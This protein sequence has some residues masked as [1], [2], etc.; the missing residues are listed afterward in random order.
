MQTDAEPCGHPR[1]EALRAFIRNPPFP[2][3][4]AKSALSRGR[5][6]VIVARDITSAWD[7]LRIYPE[8]LNFIASYRRQPDLFQSFAV[9][10]E[11]PG[12]LTEEEFERSLWA[13]AQSLS[14][15]DA[16]HGEDYDARVASDP[17][18]S[19]FSLSFGGEAFFIVGLHPRASRPARRFS[20]P[21]LVFNLHVQFERL[22][23]EGRYEKL[24]DSIMRRDEDLAGSL[25]PMLARHGE[26][27]EA[28]QY[29]GR[30]VD[31]EW[32]CPLRPRIEVGPEA[33][34]PTNPPLSLDELQVGP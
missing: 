2:C 25:N 21:V 18:N 11:G 8:L 13:R 31:A 3:V 28:R 24:R 22:R 9:V 4:G 14:D 27:S 16:W 34:W 10:F 17:D 32:R 20:S 1:A 12:D 5:M 15:K 6:H 7:D 23:A 33:A 19:H 29:S 30:S 26:I